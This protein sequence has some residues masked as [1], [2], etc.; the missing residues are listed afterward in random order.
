MDP[1]LIAQL[2]DVLVPAIVAKI[3][4]GSP[5][6]NVILTKGNG[7]GKAKAAQPATK[8]QDANT[9]PD[10]PRIWTRLADTKGARSRRTMIN[11]E[12][13]TQTGKAWT[14]TLPADAYDQIKLGQL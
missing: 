7:K 6:A 2:V 14:Q 13:H 10:A 11:L 5:N 12:T 9:D 8:P 4:T 3:G 1:K